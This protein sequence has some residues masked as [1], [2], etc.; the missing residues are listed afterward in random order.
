MTLGLNTAPNSVK[1]MA[2]T[3]VSRKPLFGYTS[4]ENSENCLGTRISLSPR[5]RLPCGGSNKLSRCHF[6]KTSADMWA[7]WDVMIIW[8]IGGQHRFVLG[9]HEVVE[10]S[11]SVDVDRVAKLKLAVCRGED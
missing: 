6:A 3:N 9:W 4:G 2:A 5:R 11:P 10:V 1:Q 7:V 8:P